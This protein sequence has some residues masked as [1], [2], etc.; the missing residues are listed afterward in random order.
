[1]HKYQTTQIINLGLAIISLLLISACKNL[2]QYVEMGEPLVSRPG[3]VAVDVAAR[4]SFLNSQGNPY[5]FC[6]HNSAR[7][8][9]FNSVDSPTGYG[10]DDKYNRVSRALRKSGAACLRGSNYA[11]EL[12]RSAALKW[13]TRSNLSR[14]SGDRNSGK[15]WNDTLTVNM[16]LLAPLA[17]MLAIAE[18]DMPLTPADSKIV[19]SWFAKMIKRFQHG[20][21]NDGRYKGGRA[22]TIARRAAHNHAAQS[23]IA[24]MSYGALFGK[25]DAFRTGLE[26][27]SITL[28]SM[29][30]DGS[31]P[32]ET[33]RGARALFYHGRTISALIQIAER[34]L[35]QNIDLYSRPTS[36]IGSLHHAIKFFLDAIRNPSLVLSYARTNH[37]PGPSKNY[38]L[39]YLGGSSTLGWIAPY[40]ARFPY[41]PNTQILKS[42]RGT[43]SYLAPQVRSAVIMNGA[44]AEWIGVDA[45]CFYAM[46]Q[47]IE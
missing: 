21:R 3:M 18:F 44:S 9:I 30:A 20:M 29:R 1:M 19:E 7:I 47:K 40:M 34:A 10:L 28:N 43:E 41:H 4:R 42:L 45:K 22:G 17:T 23:S 14:P 35:I 31:L 16:R 2:E 12:I 33:R 24:A 25:E 26:Q 8:P 27:W 36:G 38:K 15:Y 37:A 39:Q 6:T 46:P 32:I 13:A 11:C 5:T